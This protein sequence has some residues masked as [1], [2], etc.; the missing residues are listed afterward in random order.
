MHD[1]GQSPPHNFLSERLTNIV[2][3]SRTAA[4]S[5]LD[6][7]TLQDYSARVLVTDIPLPIR[8]SVTL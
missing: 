5:V 8:P 4:L 7:P 1:T 6:A 2:C 3:L